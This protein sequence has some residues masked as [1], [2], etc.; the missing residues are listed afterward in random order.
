MLLIKERNK[1]TFKLLSEPI[2]ELQ[3]NGS[4]HVPQRYERCAVA[5]AG[6]TLC[7][8]EQEST[9][10]CTNRPGL[11]QR[12]LLRAS[13]RRPNHWPPVARAIQGLSALE[14]GLQRLCPLAPARRVGCAAGC[15][16]ALSRYS[17]PGGSQGFADQAIYALCWIVKRAFAWLSQSRRLSKDYEV[18]GALTEAFVKVACIRRMVRLLG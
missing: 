14:T 1:A 16:G 4:S 13:H 10:P 17:G 18:T 12:H 6:Q 8:N 9:S 3:M 15:D 7:R 11:D 2:L 5:G